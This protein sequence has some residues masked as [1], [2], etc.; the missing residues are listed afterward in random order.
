VTK[1]FPDDEP[2][3]LK[4]GTPARL[5]LLAALIAV[6]LWAWSM[7]DLLDAGVMEAKI[8]EFGV[9]APVVFIVAYI[10]AV[11]LCLPASLLT[12]AAG[13]AFGPVLGSIYSLGGA[14]VGATISFLIAR[15]IAGDF[16]TSKWGGK[17]GHIKE[18]VD[19]E[20]WR[21]IAF[22]RLVPLFP[23]NVLNYFLGFTAIPLHQYVVTS[24]ISMAPG[25]AVYAYVGYVGREAAT[26]GQDVYL[27]VFAAVSLIAGLAMIPLLI[28]RWRRHFAEQDQAES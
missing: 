25:S 14:T 11:P 15:Y 18:G 24:L 3:A 17:I 12:L 6:M 22:V 21:F 2:R 1:P 26:G 20:G 4:L 19:A 16:A 27:K 28:K 10:V 23:F 9:W 7:R 13:A 8:G 5:I